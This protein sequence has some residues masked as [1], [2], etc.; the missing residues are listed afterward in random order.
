MSVWLVQTERYGLI[1]IHIDHG[2]VSV[3]KARELG[4]PCPPPVIQCS[5]DEAL[6]IAQALQQV[7]YEIRRRKISHIRP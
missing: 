7:A 6:E 4:T 5:S 1:G 3:D 2:E